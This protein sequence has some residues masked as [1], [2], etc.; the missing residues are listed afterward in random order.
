MKMAAYCSTNMTTLTNGNESWTRMEI[1]RPQLAAGFRNDV[2]DK[3]GKSRREKIQSNTIR[4]ALKS[5]STQMQQ[6]GVTKDNLI[7][8]VERG[9]TSSE[10]EE[11]KIEEV[12]LKRRK[13]N[14]KGGMQRIL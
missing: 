5:E 7:V 6:K 4:A 12:T 3:K 13:E 14:L 2:P 8:L 11:G 9:M 1:N 10:D